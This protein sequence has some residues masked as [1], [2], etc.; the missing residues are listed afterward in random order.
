LSE[1]ILKRLADA[2]VS[3]DEDAAKASAKEAIEAGIPPFDIILKGVSAGLTVVGQKYE[4]KEFFYPDLV[5]SADTAMRAIEIIKPHLRTEKAAYTG[6]F[7]IGT[8]E[9][10]LHDI[11]KDLVKTMLEAGGFNVIDLGVDTPTSKFV[12][13]AKK[14]NADIVGSSATLAGGTKMKQKEIEDALREAGIRD[15]IKTMVGG[16]VTDETWAREIGADAWGADCLDALKKAEELM[17]KKK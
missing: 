11:G 2:V 17:K 16:I 15:K 10:D 1:E 8:V 7:V 14:Y 9:G 12:E 4:S 6:K 3:G 5:V 13:A